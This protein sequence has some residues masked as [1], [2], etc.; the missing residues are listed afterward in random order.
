M[1]YKGGVDFVFPFP[2]FHDFTVEVYQWIS[3]FI[4]NFI[5]LVITYPSLDQSLSLLVKGA[6]DVVRY[7]NNTHF[8]LWIYDL[9]LPPPTIESLLS[10]SRVFLT[11]DNNIFLKGK[12]MDDNHYTPY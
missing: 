11:N 8:R 4:L 3:N 5:G 9:H 2:N 10:M 1:H 12:V 7:Y 6:L